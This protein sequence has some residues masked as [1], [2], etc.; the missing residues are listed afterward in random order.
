MTQTEPRPGVWRTV[1]IER[2]VEETPRVRSLS[3]AAPGWPGHLA[4]QHVDVRLTAE[5]GYQAQRSYSIASEP[6]GGLTLTIERIE[7]GEVSSYLA[8]DAQTGD[9]FQVR[10][11]IGG[12]FVW[13]PS[14]RPLLLVAG[15]SGV[16]P[17]MSMLRA[18]RA[19]TNPGR[20]MLLYSSR[21]FEDIIYREELDAMA[22]QGDG[23]TVRHTLTRRQPAGWSGYARRIDR[24]MLADA[25][26]KPSDKPETFICGPTLLVD[27]AARLLVELGHAA[28]DIKTERFG[29]SGGPA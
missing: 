4:G 3:L 14:P 28:A 24:G 21:S 22:G 26:L 10:G 13:R 5:D 1:A 17:L 2:I 12:Y 8:G 15:G 9:R 7:D 18:R 23:L 16:V 29:P 25:T 6:S 20:A 19:Y 11:P 27:A